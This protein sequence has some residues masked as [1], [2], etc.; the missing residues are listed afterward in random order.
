MK[1]VMELVQ[2]M[3]IALQKASSAR[4]G[5]YH[6]PCPG[7][8][9][10][11]RFHVWPEQNDGAGSY[12]CRKCGKGGDVIQFRR[13]FLGESFREAAGASGKEPGEYTGAYRRPEKKKPPERREFVPETYS[14]PC[15]VWRNKAGVFVAWAVKQL[16]SNVEMMQWLSARGIGQATAERFQIGYN[17]GE[18]G[19]DSYR[20]R[21]SWGL[22]TVLKDDGQ[23]KKLWLPRGIVVPFFVDGV[24]Q[25][26]R[27]RRFD[28]GGPKYYVLPGSGMATMINRPKSRAFV[29]VETEL[30][31]ILLDQE[32]GGV[33]GSIGLGSATTKPDSAAF[34]ALANSLCILNALDFD[35]AG[36]GAWGWW[37]DHFDQA[38][39]WPVPDGKDP[40]EAFAAGVD[41]KSWIL[42][43]LPPVF[44]INL[45]F[46]GG[47]TDE[48]PVEKIQVAT[49]TGEKPVEDMPDDGPCSD[50]HPDLIAFYE[51]LKK[52]PVKIRATAERTTLIEN[53]AWSAKNWDISRAISNM[54]YFNPVVLDYL[55]DHP[56]DIIHGG[57]FWDTQKHE[58]KERK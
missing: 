27:I 50:R 12:W 10:K 38:E 28:E 51:S 9:G 7:C 22:D 40:G 34:K 43:G 5:E 37:K 26:I 55:H 36:A 16:L 6:G 49:G 45:K 4:G 19:K 48:K 23:K 56:A 29:V 35:Q 21:E 42:A 32:T 46:D 2:G 24:I 58:G 57:N 54:L 41:L 39:R 15:E 53:Q 47:P 33:C 11:D 8:G 1:T 3:G 30:D 14:S 25:R 13:D 17:P 44:S 18:N 52:Y 31:A 20:T